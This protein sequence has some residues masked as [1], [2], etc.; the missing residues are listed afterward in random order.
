MNKQISLYI[1]VAVAIVLPFLPSPAMGQAEYEE[2][3]VSFEVPRLLTHD[4]FV[5]YDGKTLYLPVVEV[6]G[7]LDINIGPD[8][9]RTRLQGFVFTKDDKYEL[10]PTESKAIIKGADFPLDRTEFMFDNGEL[11]L[12]IDQFKRLFGLDMTFD[13]SMLRILLPLSESFPAWQKLKRKQA[14][15]KLTKQVASLKDIKNV[16]R[17]REW[18]S[19]GVADWTL[20]SNPIGGGG[21][22]LDLALGSMVAGGDL[23]L[24]GSGSSSSGFQSDQFNYRWHYSF[25]ENPFI[26]QTELGTINPGGSLSRSLRGALITNTPQVQRQYFQTIKLEGQLEEGWEVELFVDGRLLGF[27]EAD[28][29]GKYQFDVDIVYGSSDITLKMY[30]PNGEIRTEERHLR[31]PYNL[32]PKNNLEYSVAIGQDASADTTRNY[33]QSTTYYGVLNSLTIGVGADLPIKSDID[34]K[35]LLS[36]EATL[37]VA[38]SIIANAAYSPDYQMQFGANYAMPNFINTNL[39][40]T[41]YEVNPFRNPGNQKQSISGSMSL[42]I[43]IGERYLGIRYNA[44]Y[45]S[46]SDFSALSMNYGATASFL[47]IYANYIGRYKR[48]IYPNRSA[49][50]MLSQMLVSTDLLSW[51]RPQFRID[52]D[53]D[54]NQFSRFGVYLT[55]RVFKTGQLS[56]S[57]EHSPLYGSNMVMLNF[58]F[59]NSAA[60]FSTRA[61]Y[62]NKD[63][64]MNQMQRGS[65]RYDRAANKVRLDRRNGIGYGSAV[66]RPF[67]DLNNDGVPNKGEEFLLGMKAKI[68]GT[69]G[70]PVPRGNV[71]YYENL[72]PYDSYTISIDPTSLDNPMLKPAY[73]NYKVSVNPNVVTSVNVPVVMAADISGVIERET[74]G[75][76]VGIG[77]IRL[78]LLNVGKDV[79]FDIVSF[80]SGQYYY[81]G[82][83]PGHYRAY[84]DPEQ[85]NRY[86]YIAEPP[87][88]EFDVLPSESGSSIENI[89]FVLKP[90]P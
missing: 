36:T 19:G 51:L 90:K 79:S 17:R 14:R 38:G 37:Q 46:Y 47:R 42:P 22:Y 59:F 78:K 77:G 53:H 2:I 21:H 6:F 8:P 81:L 70:R 72:R 68:Q 65:V 50:S 25:D 9:D 15:E 5:R 61:A 30:G 84:L 75:G 56:L 33:A 23:T 85:L 54:V 4:L 66:V 45:D 3:T 40:Y 67:V 11:Y 41:K 62:S 86:G 48:T 16:D 12:R 39:T 26:S 24:S 80:S 64:S 34:E 69:G 31:V 57:Y 27:A 10:R 28:A 18:F 35:P 43:K 29:T 88:L 71:F 83:I 7:Y 73:E 63:I 32:I 20:S 74:P 49:K 1:A 87:S 13:F 55:R 60:T 76:N 89:N 44:S 82:L 58:N 52:Y